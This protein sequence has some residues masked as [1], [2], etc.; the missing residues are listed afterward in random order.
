MNS[1]IEF[2]KRNRGLV[3]GMTIGL[4]IGVLIL[5][6]NFWRTLLLAVCIGIG[7]ILGKASIREKIYRILDRILPKDFK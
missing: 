3:I 4:I 7:A 6:I 2:Y 1:F 5:T